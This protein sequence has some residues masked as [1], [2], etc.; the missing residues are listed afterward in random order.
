VSPVLSF[1][2]H[3]H[4]ALKEIVKSQALIRIRR[5][6][7][8]SSRVV[9]LDTTK[10]LSEVGG[11][12]DAHQMTWCCIQRLRIHGNQALSRLSI[13]FRPCRPLVART[14]PV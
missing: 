14:L 5:G 1:C 8:V 3:C 6:I 2:H 12:D 11:V 13:P 7:K 10:G 9:V 4:R